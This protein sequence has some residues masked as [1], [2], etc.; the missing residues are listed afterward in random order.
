M[1]DE[2]YNAIPLRFINSG[3]KRDK[4]F[5]VLCAKSSI[6]F[7]TLNFIGGCYLSYSLRV[8]GVL[9]TALEG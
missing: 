8:G 2:S 5:G 3:G 1:S 4:K 7:E 9:Y 6:V